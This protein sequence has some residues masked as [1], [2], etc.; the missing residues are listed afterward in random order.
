MLKIT[1][2]IRK[3]ENGYYIKIYDGF[4]SFIAQTF[5]ASSDEQILEV[6]KPFLERLR[7]A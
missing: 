1:V 2:K 4:W 5:I 7:E 6:L 3:C